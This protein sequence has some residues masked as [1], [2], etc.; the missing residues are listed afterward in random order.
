VLDT[1]SPASVISP[2]VTRE[3]SDYGLLQQAG[4]PQRYRLVDLTAEGAAGK[5]PLPDLT[6]RTLR[7][8]ALLQIDGLLGLDFFRQF[9]RICFD[10][11]TS[12]LIL[13]PAPPRRD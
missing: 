12:T 4:E 10:F 6:V 11:P 2:S 8:L 1:G 13:S 5:P 9:D 3:L 7:R